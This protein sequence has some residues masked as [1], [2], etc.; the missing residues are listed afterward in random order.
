MD[1]TA[2]EPESRAALAARLG[3]LR[4]N[5][6]LTDATTMPLL[7]PSECDDV[8]AQLDDSW[9]EMAVWA[10]PPDG[11]NA[12]ANL[13]DVRR[14]HQQLAPGGN[15]GP[16]ATR[17]VEHVLDVNARIYRFCIVG[18]EHPMQVLR[19]S[20]ES[21]DG[22]VSHMDIGAGSS[23]RKLSFSLLLSDPATFD[24][25]DLAFGE[26]FA[27]ARQQGTLTVFPSFLAHAVTP[28]TRGVR[29]A[30]VGFMIGPAFS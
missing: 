23:M 17:I 27:L 15:T 21:S 25:C 4:S 26:P 6:N 22:Y 19:Y 11:P 10:T 13:P 20:G 8:I 30:V 3:D 12:H 1:G 9:G 7:A 16:L 14:G 29:Y 24:G 2:P 5:P 18:V 28:V